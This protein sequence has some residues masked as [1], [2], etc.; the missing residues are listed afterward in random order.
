MKYFLILSLFFYG[1]I[2]LAMAQKKLSAHENL[3]REI[4]MTQLYRGY[5]FGIIQQLE[6]THP[7]NQKVMASLLAQ[8]QQ[9]YAALVF[10]NK[11]LEPFDTYS[12]SE[13]ES[14]CS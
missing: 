8:G 3:R 14:I 6:V 10:Q 9:K 4:F 13:L 1:S 12:L 11:E 5:S 7:V 2:S